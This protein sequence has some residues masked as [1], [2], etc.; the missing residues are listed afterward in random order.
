MMHS[1]WEMI[2]HQKPRMGDVLSVPQRSNLASGLLRQRSSAASALRAGKLPSCLLSPRP[3]LP[4]GRKAKIVCGMRWRRTRRRPLP[5]YRRWCPPQSIGLLPCSTR[6]RFGRMYSVRPRSLPPPPLLDPVLHQFPLYLHLHQ[7]RV[8]TGPR[9]RIQA[10]PKT[11]KA[12][13]TRQMSC[14]RPMRSTCLSYRLPCRPRPRR[15]HPGRR[16]RPGFHHHYPRPCL[17]CRRCRRRRWAR[18]SP[19][20]RGLGTRPTEVTECRKFDLIHFRYRHAL[21]L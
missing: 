2:W 1:T 21:P 6:S 11:R 4:L 12:C 16:R 13:G 17:S 18:R 5:V 15:R 20:R 9:R 3:A 8:Q 10:G 14:L 7:H 19:C